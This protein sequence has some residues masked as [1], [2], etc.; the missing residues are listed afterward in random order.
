MKLHIKICFRFSSV[1]M[2]ILFVCSAKKSIWWHV[3]NANSSCQLECYQEIRFWKKLPKN[4]ITIH[5]NK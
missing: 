5:R 4:I 1:Q 2:V 3:Q